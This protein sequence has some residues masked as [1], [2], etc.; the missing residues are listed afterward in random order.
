MLALTRNKARYA[1]KVQAGSIYVDGKGIG[2]IGNVV[3]K[4][5][6][7]LSEDGLLSAIVTIDVK[8]LVVLGKPA[9]I[10]RGFIYMREN[11]ELTKDISNLVS[12]YIQNKINTMKKVN[13]ILLKKEITK[14]LNDYIFS[15]TERSPMIMPVIMI[16]N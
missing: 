7:L 2:D 11:E 16:I 9:I 12:E 14:L 1:G 8:N 13:I 5:R 6:R 10:S 15:K 3:I 4:D